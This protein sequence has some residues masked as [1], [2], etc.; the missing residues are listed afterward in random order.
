MIIQSGKVVQLGYVLKDSDGEILDESDAQRPFAYLHGAHQIVPGLENALEGLK[1]GD[2]KN[3]TVEPKEGYGELD[4]KLKLV[5]KRRQFD[6]SV[7]LE[8]GMQ[9][10]GDHGMVFVIEKL[11]GENVHIDGNHPLAGE[12][13][14]FAVEVLQIRDATEE[15]KTHGHS[16]GPGGAHDHEH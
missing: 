14:H 2:K 3:V 5:V 15:E 13:L 1:P 9:F 8:P 6:A 11:E 12:T 4:P 10:E 7:Q 16:H